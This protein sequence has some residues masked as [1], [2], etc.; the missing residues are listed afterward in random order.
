MPEPAASAIDAPPV[1][2]RHADQLEALAARIRVARAVALDTESNSLHHFPEQVCLIQVAEESGAASLVDPLILRDLSPLAPCCADPGIVKVFHGAPYDLSSLKRDFGF[3]FARIF[4]TMLAAQFLGLP[5]LGLSALLQRYFAIPPTRSRQKDDWTARP[6]SPEQ[7]AYAT[8]D[9]RH[10]LALREHLV[11]ELAS[12]G[13]EAWVE[14]EC[15]ALAELP[16]VERVFEPDDAF[17]LKGL[18]TLDRR[19]LA[20]L[21]EL[22]VA[23]EGWARATGRPPFRVLGNDTMLRLAA[24]RPRSAEGLVRIPGCTRRWVDRYGAGILAAI[25]RAEALPEAALPVPHRARKPRTPAAVERRMAA[26]AAWRVEA[27]AR[28]GLDP[29]LL[30]PRRLMERLAETPPADA[31]GLLAIPGFRRWRTEHFGQE[32]LRVLQG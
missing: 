23:R 3:R 8:E 5:E 28:S 6:L 26:L 32:I 9:V 18:G 7:E 12:R 11:Q 10:L 29:G 1:W 22:F 13:R 27:A 16:A 21:R 15:E 25:Q 30:L 20:A 31:E 2:V 17:R 4:D 19:A 14:E 24:E